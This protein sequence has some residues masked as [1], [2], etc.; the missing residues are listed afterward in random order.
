MTIHKFFNVHLID[1]THAKITFNRQKLVFFDSTHIILNS[2]RQLWNITMDVPQVD[3][4]DITIHEN[5]SPIYDPIIKFQITQIPQSLDQY[6]KNVMI[7]YTGPGWLN[8][9]GF[10]IARLGMDERINMEYDIS[11]WTRVVGPCPY[12]DEHDVLYVETYYVSASNV[13]QRVLD[14]ISAFIDRWIKDRTLEYGVDEDDK[15]CQIALVNALIFFLNDGCDIIMGHKTGHMF[16]DPIDIIL[17]RGT[18]EHLVARWK[19]VSMI[20]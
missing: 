12:I 6:G 13:I 1:E 9:N 8:I 14:R 11:K 18:D 4:M 10:N 7:D 19:D 3:K 16:L 15:S 5:T 2:I 17:E 20:E